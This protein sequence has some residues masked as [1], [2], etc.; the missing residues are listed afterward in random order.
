MKGLTLKGLLTGALIGGSAAMLY[1]VMNWQTQRR[2]NRMAAQ[3]GQWVA[4][5]TDELFGKK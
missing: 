4:D 5:K 1:G 2:W 3:G